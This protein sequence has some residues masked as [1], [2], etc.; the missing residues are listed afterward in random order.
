[1]NK[2]TEEIAL[3]V[4]STAVAVAMIV[5]WYPK[6]QAQKAAREATVVA[7]KAWELDQ[8]ILKD[9]DCAKVI[10][11]SAL[12][13]K[14]HSEA[15]QIWNL[16][17]VCEFDLGKL[18][19]AKASFE[20]VLSLDPNSES[21]KNYLERLNPKPGEIVVTGPVVILSQTDFESAVGLTLP[22]KNFQFIEADMRTASDSSEHFSAVYRST[23]SYG[24][25]VS[26]LKSALEKTTAKFTT[27]VFDGATVF[28]IASETEQKTFTVINRDPVKIVVKYFKIK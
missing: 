9:R 23:E 10:E 25:A 17:G 26:L 6:Y 1:M 20:K 13:L 27:Q 2:K 28:M 19:E 16:K 3:L 7:D 8:L 4:V 5:F 15:V 14:T 22:E 18:D 21:A 11:S 12:F 24:R